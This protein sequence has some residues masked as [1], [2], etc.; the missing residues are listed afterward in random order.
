VLIGENAFFYHFEN[1]YEISKYFSLSYL[2]FAIQ[3]VVNIIKAGGSERQKNFPVISKTVRDIESSVGSTVEGYEISF[4][5]L[6]T[7]INIKKY[8]GLRW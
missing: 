7:L 3:S 1:S 2:F 4:N 6:L 8:L 5:G